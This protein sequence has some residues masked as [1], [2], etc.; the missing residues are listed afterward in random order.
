MY[1]CCVRACVLHVRMCE[2]RYMVQLDESGK[3][4]KVKPENAAMQV[5]GSGPGPRT[6]TAAQARPC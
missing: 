4:L 6:C 3:E 1:V 2:N 5:S